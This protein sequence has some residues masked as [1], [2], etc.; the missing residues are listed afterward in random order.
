MENLVWEELEELKLILFAYYHDVNPWHLADWV[1]LAIG[2]LKR[3]TAVTNR[4]IIIIIYSN[5]TYYIGQRP[6]V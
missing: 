5:S 4:V 3:Y 6:L 1:H 2:D